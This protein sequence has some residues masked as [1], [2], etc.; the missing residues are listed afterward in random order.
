MVFVFLDIDG[1][2]HPLPSGGQHFRKDNMDALENA[3]SDLPV[4]I[5]IT[6]TWRES[7][8]LDELKV[9]LGNLGQH[10]L[11]V[12]PVINDLIETGLR[13]AEVDLYWETLGVDYIP[14]VAID[15][16]ADYYRSDAPLILTKSNTGFTEADGERLRQWIIMNIND[17]D[18]IIG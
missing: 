2:C 9:Y 8:T 3:L 18:N 12:T 6:S 16:T 7:K 1:V 10:V 15:D 5:V 11:G 13:H 17:N 4:Q 14:W